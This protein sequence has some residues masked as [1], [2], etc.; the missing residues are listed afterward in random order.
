MKSTQCNKPKLTIAFFLILTSITTSLFAQKNEVANFYN[1]N[2]SIFLR[3][4]YSVSVSWSAAIWYEQ[5]HFQPAINYSANLILGRKML[6]NKNRAGSRFQITQI[7]SPVFIGGLRRNSMY[8][9]IS[10]LYKDNSYSVLSNFNNHFAVGSNFILTPKSTKSILN[11]T[12]ITRQ[13]V[14]TNKNRAQ[15]LLYLGV[16][17][18]WVS[19]EKS[20]RRER[21]DSLVVRNYNSFFLDFPEDNMILPEI[22]HSFADHF[23]R[24]YTGGLAL[25]YSKFKL[26]MYQ[27]GFSSF[28]KKFSTRLATE[29]YTGTFKRDLFDYPDIY[30]I[31]AN[32]FR[33]NDEKQRRIA[34]YVAQEPGQRL[35]N[36]GQ[37]YLDIDIPIWRGLSVHNFKFNLAY[38]NGKT[39]LLVQDWN[40]NSSKIN[41]INPTAKKFTKTD[42]DFF[43][44]KGKT[45]LQDKEEVKNKIFFESLHHFYTNTKYGYFTAGVNYQH[46]RFD[47]FENAI[48]PFQNSFR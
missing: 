24:F 5:K 9:P 43:P 26:K 32:R 14:Y 22:F 10:T 31:K 7:L 47:A 39:G 25:S 34:R 30:D 41:K 19:K 44:S 15:Q 3:S 1:T 12:K 13:N 27:N 20:N 38:V 42:F 48:N 40:H 8:L 36:Q 33:S 18:G 45:I 28:E 21:K 23:D 4:D 37:T 2:L 11:P 6:G 16:R 46:T 17:L 35:Y 29:V